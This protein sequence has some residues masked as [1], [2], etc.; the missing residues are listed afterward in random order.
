MFLSSPVISCFWFFV[1]VITIFPGAIAALV[2]ESAF[3]LV[4]ADGTPKRPLS[5]R[6]IRFPS[7]ALVT[8]SL[9]LWVFVP[10]SLS[11]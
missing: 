2:V 9:S 7:L 6:G 5:L 11:Y 3:P 10:G 8:L 4:A 1:S